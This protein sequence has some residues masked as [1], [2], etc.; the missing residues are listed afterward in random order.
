MLKTFSKLKEY[1]ATENGFVKMT[2]EQLK[3]LQSVLLQ[4]LIDFHNLCEEN[5]LT[6]FLTGGSALGAARHSGFIPWDDDVDVFMPREDYERLSDIVS[7][8]CCNGYWVQ[9]LHTSDK[10]DLN[11]SKFRKLGTKYVELYETDP[12][13]AGICIDVYPLDATY[14]GD[15]AR[16]LYGIVGEA[17]FLIASCVRM[18]QKEEKLLSY[19]KD[20]QLARSIKLKSFIGRLFHSNKNPRKWFLYCEDWCKRVKNKQIE[21]VASS[22]GR[23]HYFGEL[24]EYGKLYPPV[25]AAFEGHLFYVAR[26]NDYLLRILYGNN[27]LIPPEEKK[28]E[29]HALLEVSITTEEKRQRDDE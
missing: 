17:F 8:K 18:H 24:Y 12:E 20:A 4:M 25:L 23:G 29:S 11:F 1:A 21:Y 10:Y 14:Q 13:R 2:P 7:K 27:Y 19:I 3:D 6:Y 5:H 22:S 28:V 15:I 9:N 16:F 26:D